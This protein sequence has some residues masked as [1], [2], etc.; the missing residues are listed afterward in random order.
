[1]H[2]EG[3]NEDEEAARAVAASLRVTRPSFRRRQPPEQR[4]AVQPGSMANVRCSSG[5]AAALA[6]VVT[7]G[8]V[9]AVA[10]HKLSKANQEDPAQSRAWRWWPHLGAQRN[11]DEV[12]NFDTWSASGSIAWDF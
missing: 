11:R 9:T 1:M 5:R 7:L 4:A 8:L 3:R 10:L 2:R 12:R 6:T